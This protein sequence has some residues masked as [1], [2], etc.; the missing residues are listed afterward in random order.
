MKKA[1]AFFFVLFVLAIALAL[2]YLVY[3]MLPDETTQLLGFF[4]TNPLLLLVVIIVVIIFLF[5]IP[6]F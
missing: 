2:F 4:I 3:K 6:K 1:E 5:A